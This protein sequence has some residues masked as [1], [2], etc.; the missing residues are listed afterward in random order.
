VHIAAKR[1][2]AFGENVRAAREE[3]GVGGAMPPVEYLEL[4]TLMTAQQAPA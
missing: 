1:T 2:G 3:V 4:H